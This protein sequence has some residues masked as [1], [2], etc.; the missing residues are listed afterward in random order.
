MFLAIACN[1]EQL[2]QYAVQDL[3]IVSKHGFI[4]AAHG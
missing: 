4:V 3:A 2:M 1:F